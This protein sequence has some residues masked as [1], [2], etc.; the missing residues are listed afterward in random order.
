MQGSGYAR[1]GDSGCSVENYLPEFAKAVAKLKPGRGDEQSDISRLHQD[2][3]AAGYDDEYTL[4][5]MTIKYAGLRG[6]DVQ[7][8]GKNY[9]IF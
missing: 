2:A 4:L 7:F 8:F 5:G 3:F 6:V 9:A 1:G